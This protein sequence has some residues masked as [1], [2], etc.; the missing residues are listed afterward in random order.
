MSSVTHIVF[1]ACRFGCFFTPSKLGTVIFCAD[2]GV[3]VTIVVAR[4]VGDSAEK[5]ANKG[6]VDGVIEGA[7]EDSVELEGAVG[8]AKSRYG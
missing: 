1:C 3:R 4:D 6:S 7:K 5:G 2:F 8:R